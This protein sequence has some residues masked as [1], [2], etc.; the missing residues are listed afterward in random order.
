MKVITHN[1]KFH[2]DEVFAIAMLEI[3]FKKIEVQRIPPQ[4]NIDE[5]KADFVVDIGKKYDAKKY[6]DHHQFTP[7]EESRSNAGMALD[8]LIEN[9]YFNSEWETVKAFIEKVD[10]NDIGIERADKFSIITII[11]NLNH[12]S[13]HT[14]KQESQ[15]KKAVRI[16]KEALR[17]LIGKDRDMLKAK[18][19]IAKKGKVVERANIKMVVLPHFVPN[20]ERVINGDNKKYQNIDWIAWIDTKEGTVKVKN[21]PK[22]DG[23]F[24][25]NGIPVRYIEGVDAIFLHKDNFFGV[26]ENRQ[27][28]LNYAEKLSKQIAFEATVGGAK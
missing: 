1:G 24:E 14:K 2:A 16:A 22:A 6:F 9:G 18:E 15:F 13:L 21:I 20:W 25:A 26:F 23:N 7:K 28:L 19:I 5:I 4:S 11:N 17:G 3:A 8:Y 12:S 10:K 27:K